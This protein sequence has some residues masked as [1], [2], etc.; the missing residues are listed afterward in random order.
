[1]RANSMASKVMKSYSHL[2]VFRPFLQS[3]LGEM[4]RNTLET[5]ESHS[6]EVDP[7]KLGETNNNDD[8]ESNQ[9][10]LL[11]AASKFLRAIFDS[12]D[13]SPL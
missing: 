4:I 6:F 7:E 1:M 13:D 8:L 10:R 2:K 12:L 9:Q 5:A 11:A 3:V